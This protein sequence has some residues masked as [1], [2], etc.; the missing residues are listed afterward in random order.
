MALYTSFIVFTGKRNFALL[1][2]SGNPLIVLYAT[3]TNG[4]VQVRVK[5]Q[6]LTPGV[7]HR[8]NT[9]AGTQVL[10]KLHTFSCIKVIH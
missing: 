8:G 6:L 4:K 7:Q 10:W 2:F 3:A 5:A 9:N 1:R